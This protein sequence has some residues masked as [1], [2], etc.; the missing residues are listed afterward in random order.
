VTV[1][2][3]R[4]AEMVA[5]ATELSDEY[6]LAVPCFGHA[7]DG[8]MHFSVIADPD[9]PDEVERAHDCYEAITKRALELDGTV[10]G[11][12][13]IGVG[14]RDYL[15]DEHGDEGVALMG[16]VKRAFDPAGILNPGKV[17]PGPDDESDS[18]N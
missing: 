2:I 3:G 15:A 1:P 13:G 7:G 16:R 18:A 8:N 5:E 10:T 9:D 12:H 14:K 17:L 11:E 4:Y 6:G